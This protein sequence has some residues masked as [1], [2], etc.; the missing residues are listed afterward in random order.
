[1]IILPSQSR[2]ARQLSRTR[3]SQNATY[4][5]YCL[6]RVRG[7]WHRT[8]K[9]TVTERATGRRN[10]KESHNKTSLRPFGQRLLSFAFRYGILL[11]GV[12]DKRQAVCPSGP[13]L[14]GQGHEQRPLPVAETGSCEWRSAPVFASARRGAPQKAAKRK[15]M[16]LP[17]P[18]TCYNP[19][20]SYKM[21]TP[22]R[23]IPASRGGIKTV[24]IV[25]FV[26]V[27]GLPGRHLE[28]MAANDSRIKNFLAG[29]Y[30]KSGVSKV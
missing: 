8:R 4:R 3:E 10:G 25:A 18:S 11:L 2:F 26:G 16:Q 6:P 7:R 12:V 17:A 21:N 15:R 27:Q 20:N 13:T 5:I 24:E 22:S 28:N 14:C 30:S 23:A 9:R 19:Y 29:R 1:M